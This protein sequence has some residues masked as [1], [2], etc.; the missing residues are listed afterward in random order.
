MLLMLLK[1]R[2]HVEFGLEQTT[3]ANFV[4]YGLPDQVS[5]DTFV[6]PY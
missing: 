5:L 4:R 6:K 2:L 1:L 3:F